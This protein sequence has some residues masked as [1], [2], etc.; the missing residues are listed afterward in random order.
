MSPRRAAIWIGAFVLTLTLVG[1]DRP[2]ADVAASSAPP[3]VP[4]P[5][6]PGAGASAK[7]TAAGEPISPERRRHDRGAHALRADELLGVPRR[8]CRWGYGSEPA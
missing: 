2:T 1:C 8:P 5:V 6:G 7:P 3:A 4:T